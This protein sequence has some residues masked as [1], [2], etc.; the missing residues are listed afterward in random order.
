[1]VAV[2]GV[3]DDQKLER[4]ID[5]ARQT[6]V[7]EAVNFNCPGQTVVAG[8]ELAGKTHANCPGK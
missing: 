4:L 1:M 3:R 8:D 2:L 5:Q 7:L 6:G